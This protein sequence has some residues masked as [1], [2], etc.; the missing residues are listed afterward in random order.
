MNTYPTTQLPSPQ[1]PAFAPPVV[2]SVAQAAPPS[3]PVAAR[4]STNV[5]STRIGDLLHAAPRSLK[6]LYGG[7]AAIVL[8]SRL[9]VA[10][11]H[12]NGNATPLHFTSSG[13]I[14]LVSFAAAFVWLSLP[15]LRSRLSGVR[16]TVMAAVTGLAGLLTFAF[17]SQLSNVAASADPLPELSSAYDLPKPTADAGLGLLLLTLGVGLVAV[18]TIGLWVRRGDA[19]QS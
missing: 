18:G 2:A 11:L 3:Q 5:A 1:L 8:A 9:P 15:A 17:Y 10:T 6:L 19:R 14:V 13:S 16:A 7:V 12:H 4:T